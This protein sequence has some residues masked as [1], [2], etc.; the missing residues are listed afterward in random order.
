MNDAETAEVWQTAFGKDFGG[1]AQGDDKT[2]QKGTNSVFVTTHKKRSTLQNSQA[3]NGLTHELWSTTDHKKRIPIAS[4]SQSGAT[5]SH[6]KATHQ[7]E[8]PI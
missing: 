8:Q 1:M 6:I 3:T 7:H 5:S 4:E 2:G